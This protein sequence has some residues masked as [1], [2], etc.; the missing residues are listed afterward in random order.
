M[1]K[2][3]S[4]NVVYKNPSEVL[5]VVTQCKESHLEGHSYQILDTS[6]REEVNVVAI[7]SFPVQKTKGQQICHLYLNDPQAISAMQEKIK[8]E[9]RQYQAWI[10]N[11]KILL[12]NIQ[13]S[14]IKTISEHRNEWKVSIENILK[15]LSIE[16]ENLLEERKRT[17]EEIQFLE[18][19]L[20]KMQKDKVEI[21]N[22]IY[23]YHPLEVSGESIY[24]ST[25]TI[26]PEESDS[27]S[28]ETVVSE[29]TSTEYVRR[30]S[31]ESGY[32]SE[33]SVYSSTET[34]V[35]ESESVLMQ[36]NTQIT[37]LE[38][39]NKIYKTCIESL[40]KKL[41]ANLTLNFIKL[42]ETDLKV[43]SFKKVELEQENKKNEEAIQS[44]E[45]QI[46]EN[47]EIN[48]AYQDLL[49]EEIY[50]Y[51]LDKLKERL[52]IEE[53]NTHE[54]LKD[55]EKG[56]NTLQEKVTELNPVIEK[57]TECLTQTKKFIS[58]LKT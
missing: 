38:K 54:E 25:E 21:I 19:L 9:N 4:K 26:L 58:L 48:V 1:L 31:K 28:M 32:S 50:L 55:I 17:A 33:E 14:K 10:R 37:K 16:I 18:K 42:S 5:P 45:A 52:E 13:K 34:I 7:A 39:K 30:I 56:I 2:W 8:Q 53:E 36:T 11:I 57:F 40:N 6:F 47:I 24:S 41:N 35:P 22:A 29:K 44:L 20:E 51:K 23:R 43:L 46:A 49:S 27:S 15:N 3:C 12:K